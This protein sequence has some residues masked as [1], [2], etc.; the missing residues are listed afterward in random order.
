MNRALASEDWG[1]CESLKLHHNKD[2]KWTF[3]EI[4]ASDWEC[5]GLH[6]L[7]VTRFKVGTYCTMCRH[8]ATHDDKL[9]TVY[10]LY[11]LPAVGNDILSAVHAAPSHNIVNDMRLAVRLQDIVLLTAG[12]LHYQR[13]RQIGDCTGS[14]HRAMCMY[15][16]L[17]CR[18]E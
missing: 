15:P 12:T 18:V 10:A 7:P 5:C 17:L 6:L 8:K 1:R 14:A 13:W 4:T 9:Y 16:A 11:A 2:C 3:R